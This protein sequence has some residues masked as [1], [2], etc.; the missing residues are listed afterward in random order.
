VS[1]PAGLRYDQYGAAE[2]RMRIGPDD[3]PEILILPPLFEEMNRTRSLLAAIMRLLAG[4]GFLCTLP[5][6][7]GTGESE[8][9][10]D[11]IGWSDW[12]DAATLAAKPALVA[13][14]RGGALLDHGAAAPAWRFAPVSG[15]SLVRDLERAGLA[16]GAPLAGYPVPP[17]LLDA[18]R[19]SEPADVS[20][21]RTVRL[22]SDAQ[23]A[24]MRVAGSAL[25]RRSEPANAPD[26]ASALAADLA[27]WGA[28]CGAC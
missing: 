2:W 20:P 15:R 4:R 27:S 7:P 23:P 24:D 21:L 11:A 28:A 26:L 8:R 14:F 13:S 9:P 5:D 3:G 12:Q 18:L 22:E 6:L 16:G 1:D 17:S 19:H 25:W 10:L